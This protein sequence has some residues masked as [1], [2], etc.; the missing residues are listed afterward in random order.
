MDENKAKQGYD[1]PIFSEMR[2][3]Q[4]G[5]ENHLVD[6]RGLE[7]YQMPM[8]ESEFHLLSDTGDDDSDSETDE[9]VSS[10]SG[11]TD[12]DGRRCLQ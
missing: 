3:V 6:I 11:G 4:H 1:S 2:Y 12:E 7:D 5:S 8:P 9:D 10:E